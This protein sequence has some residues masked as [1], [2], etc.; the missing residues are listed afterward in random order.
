[1]KDAEKERLL[2]VVRALL[3]RGTAA[4]QE[5]HDKIRDRL[6]ALSD[7]E[8]SEVLM[9]LLGQVLLGEDHGDTSGVEDEV[10]AVLRGPDGEIKQ[11]IGKGE[12]DG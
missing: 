7:A 5:L 12:T 4:D 3:T 8:R 6:M 2:N 11:T 10:T 1:M 9:V